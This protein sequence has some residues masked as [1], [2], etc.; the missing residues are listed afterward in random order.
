MHI[1]VTQQSLNRP[2]RNK[3]LEQ[4]RPIN[5]PPQL[6]DLMLQGTLHEGDRKS[7]VCRKSVTLTMF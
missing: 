3:Y 6:L 4:Y 5:Y 1:R 7:V 2:H